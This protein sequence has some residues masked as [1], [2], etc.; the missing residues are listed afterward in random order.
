MCLLEHGQTNKCTV[1]DATE[2]PTNATMANK[3][4]SIDYDFRLLWKSVTQTQMVSLDGRYNKG[5]N[6]SK[7]A[8]RTCLGAEVQEDGATTKLQESRV[9]RL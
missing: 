4:R 8:D 1:T 3:V 2:G 7:D 9:H 6:D 5:S